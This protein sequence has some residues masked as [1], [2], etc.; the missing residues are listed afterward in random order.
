MSSTAAKL[1][2]AL[3]ICAIGL[4]SS[5]VQVTM[6]RA[7]DDAAAA[8][9]ESAAEERH[10]GERWDVAVAGARAQAER[11][12]GPARTAVDIVGDL[13]LPAERER[14][15]DAIAALDEA[16]EG[17]DIGAIAARCSDLENEFVA[18]QQAVVRNA[19][20]S[21]AANGS[22]D[23]ASRSDLTDAIDAIRP[24]PDAGPVPAS[25]FARLRSVADQVV[26]SHQAAITAAAAAA[27]AAAGEA[28]GAAVSDEADETSGASSTT[29]PTSPPLAPGW[30]V[31]T[32]PALELNGDFRP[33]CEVVFGEWDWWYENTPGY[34][35]VDPGYP[36]DIE[37][38]EYEGSYLGVKSLPCL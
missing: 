36:Y 16:S 24:G 14:L 37:I 31:R 20:S 38:M 23:A 28:A 30:V 7:A 25:A 15:A 33:G 17:R 3:L 21:L 18:F 29:T 13:A 4:G 27:A 32:P 19:E 22:A 12:A 11:A 34:V 8:A 9:V 1:S 5:A 35:V 6:A 26:A 10:A 2:I